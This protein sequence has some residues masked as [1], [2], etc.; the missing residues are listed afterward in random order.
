[1]GGLDIFKAIPTESGNYSVENMKYPINS[2]S[3]DF[4]F[5][6]NGNKTD[7]YLSSSRKSG[8]GDDI[9]HY[10]MQPL[11]ITLEGVVINEKNHAYIGDAIVTLVGSNGQQF[12]TKTKGNGTFSFK[13]DEHTDYLI[14]TIKENFLKGTANETTKGITENTLIEVEIYMKPTLT[15]INIPNIRYD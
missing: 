1:M 5:I 10:Y 14:K 7:G 4:A 15:A 12:K 3:N 13:L 6:V 9:F 2:P 11:D 8:A